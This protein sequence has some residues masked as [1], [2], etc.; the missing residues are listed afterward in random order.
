MNNSVK[1]M[2]RSFIAVPLLV[3]VAACSWFEGS[4]KPKSSYDD[5]GKDRLS[6]LS[7]TRIIEAD[8][9]LAAQPV[10]LPRPYTNLS[11]AQAG[12]NATH[13]I[14]HLTVGDTLSKAWSTNIGRGNDTYHRLVAGPVSANG[15]VY[16]MDVRASVSAVDLAS[17]RKRWSVTLKDSTE[18]SNVGYGGGVAYSDGILFATTG[19]GFTVALDAGTGA[20]IWRHEGKIPMRG[21]P[22]VAGNRVFTITHDNQ[23]KVLNAATGI[24]LWDQVGISETASMLGAASPAVDEGVTVIALS[25]GELMAMQVSNGRVL[26]QDSL[27]SSKR[28]TPLASLADVDG[29]PVIDRGRAYAVSHAGRMVAIDMRTGERSWESDVASVNTPLVAGNYAFVSTIEGEIASI[30]LSDGR[31]RWVTQVQRFDDQEKRRGLI[32]WNGPILAGD[33][34]LMTSSHGYLVSVSPYSGAVLSAEKLEAGT[35]T[36]P[37]VVDNT[38]VYLDDSGNLVAYR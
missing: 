29:H 9:A 24:E 3:S 7:S 14:Y 1:K 5:E 8:P 20:E 23:I 12:G 33:R 10:I 22:T 37:I 19:Y 13:A 4:S 26:W 6:I 28:L 30:Q 18:K 17:G 32:K 25:S 21:A 2:A 38:L 27:T 35:S 36:P 16:A 31:V 15:V 11:W 34:L